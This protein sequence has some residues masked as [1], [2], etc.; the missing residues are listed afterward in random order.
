MTVA[1]V[2]G[3]IEL[4]QVLVNALGLR[5]DFC[6]AV[7]RVDFGSL[8][9]VVVGLFMFA[10]IASAAVWKFGHLERYGV[11]RMPQTHPSVHDSQAEHVHEHL[12]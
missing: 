3:S 11:Q 5:G 10:W 6:D 1:L 12:N 8:G 4:L 7:A 2:I 9:C